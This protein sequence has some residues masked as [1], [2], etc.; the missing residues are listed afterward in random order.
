MNKRKKFLGYCEICKKSL[1][2][3]HAYFYVDGNNIAITNNSPYLCKTCYEKRY[4][5]KIESEVE[6]FKNRLINSLLNLKII[7]NIET[8]EIKKLINFI[9]GGTYNE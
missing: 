5:E 6:I 7:N 3:E 4:N 9:K 2:E 1:C 8:I